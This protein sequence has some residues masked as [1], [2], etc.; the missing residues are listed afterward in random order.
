MLWAENFKNTKNK[1]RG[2]LSEFYGIFIWAK[3]TVQTAE[4][5]LVT[6]YQNLCPGRVWPRQ[7]GHE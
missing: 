5:E 6:I 2:F 4:N 3:P 7:S 1:P